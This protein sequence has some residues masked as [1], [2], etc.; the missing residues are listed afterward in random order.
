M[1][2]YEPGRPKIEE[3]EAEYITNG[4]QILVDGGVEWTVHDWTYAPPWS[5]EPEGTLIFYLQREVNGRT[6]AVRRPVAPGELIR[7]RVP[8]NER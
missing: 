4:T 1:N 6:Q 3:R 2:G 7:C 5:G 8:E